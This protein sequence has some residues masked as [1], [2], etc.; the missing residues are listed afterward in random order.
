MDS[1]P[2]R[3]LNNNNGHPS[4]S[5][6]LPILQILVRGNEDFELCLLVSRD[7]FAILQAGPASFVGCFYQVPNERAAQRRR[8]ALVKQNAHLRHFERTSC[9]VLEHGAGLIDSHAGKPIDK[10]VYRGVVFEVLEQRGD[11][12]PRPGRPMRRSRDRDHV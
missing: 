1:R 8:R 9:C 12:H 6:V 11:G 2:T 4:T 7:K 5:K 3:R 10:L